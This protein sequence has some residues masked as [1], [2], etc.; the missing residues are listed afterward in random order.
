MSHLL[1]IG[2]YVDAYP[3]KYLIPTNYMNIYHQLFNQYLA[4]F[5][6]KSRVERVGEYSVHFQMFFH[7]MA[8]E[9]LLYP[10][11]NY[12]NTL[13]RVTKNDILKKLN[14]NQIAVD[15]TD[16][17]HIRSAL[18]QSKGVYE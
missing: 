2:N 5:A 14:S 10:V 13:S 9:Y 16:L 11:N 1:G 12:T 18:P 6:E 4:W 15:S 7:Y 8:E 3:G 17:V